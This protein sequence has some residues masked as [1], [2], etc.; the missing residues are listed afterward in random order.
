M[1]Y[2]RAITTKH[3]YFTGYTTI[4]NELLTEKER[5]AKFRY[6]NDC[7]FELVNISSRNTYK[8]FGARFEIGSGPNYD[9]YGYFTI[10]CDGTKLYID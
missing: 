9:K 6:L 4:Y 7:C 10:T 1:K 8:S 2:Y 3:D 5:N